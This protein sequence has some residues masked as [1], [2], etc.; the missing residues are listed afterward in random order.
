MDSRMAW[1]L[2]LTA[3]LLEVVWAIALKQAAG[4][5]RLLP[6][7]VGVAAA[8]AS[9]VLLALALKGLPVGPA[10]AIWVG[11]GVIGTAA[12]GVVALGEPVT[13]ARTACLALILLG[14]VGLKVVDA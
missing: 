5:S 1:L 10:Y 2:L 9:F 11:M 4:F 14:V 12:V 6:S 7:V 13:P 8:S 3:G